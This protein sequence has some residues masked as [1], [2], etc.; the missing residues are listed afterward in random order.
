M[1]Q[2]AGWARLRDTKTGLTARR[3]FMGCFCNLFDN[4]TF[5][6]IIVIILLL[7]ILNN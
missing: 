2:E 5:I 6:W 4:D 7:V 1:K 3:F